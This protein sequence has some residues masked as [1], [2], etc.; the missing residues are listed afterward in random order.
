MIFE[1]SYPLMTS[2]SGAT[3]KIFARFHS[4]SDDL[5][6]A[7]RT[8]RSKHSDRAFKAVECIRFSAHHNLKGFFVGIPTFITSF[9]ESSFGDESYFYKDAWVTDKIKVTKNQY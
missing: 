3:K 7:R 1:I 9:H 6:S 8:N 2:A 4:M 5:S